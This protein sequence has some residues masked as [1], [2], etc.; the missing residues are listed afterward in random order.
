MPSNNISLEEFVP[1]NNS[2]STIDIANGKV[3]D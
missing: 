1:K 3:S 2:L